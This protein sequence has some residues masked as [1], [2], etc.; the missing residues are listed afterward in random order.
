MIT[1]A[2][3]ALAVSST[4]HG[5]GSEA[6]VNSVLEMGRVV[7]VGL[8]TARTRSA[9][10]RREANAAILAGKKDAKVSQSLRIV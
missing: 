5:G 6:R 4:P 3:R 2:A 10:E 8:R 9:Q 1:P 7:R